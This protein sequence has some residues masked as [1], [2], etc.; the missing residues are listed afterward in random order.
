MF[1]SRYRGF[2]LALIGVAIMFA[3]TYLG[4]E[5]NYEKAN[6]IGYLG[7]F[8]IMIGGI[9]HYVD[10]FSNLL[11]KEERRKRRKRLE[12]KQPWEKGY[13]PKSQLDDDL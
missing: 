6:G 7:F 1:K 12:P 4:I 10:F 13:D 5:L 11:N 9:I 8:V 2:K 3:A